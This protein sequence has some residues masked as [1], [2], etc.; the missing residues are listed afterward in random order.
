[1]RL[2]AR[3]KDSNEAAPAIHH[4]PNVWVPAP[5]RTNGLRRLSRSESRPNVRLAAI[6]RIDCNSID[7]NISYRNVAERTLQR[8]DEEQGLVGRQ[9]GDADSEQQAARPCAPEVSMRDE[10][11]AK[12]LRSGGRVSGRCEPSIAQDRGEHQDRG[13]AEPGG[14]H[15][16]EHYGIGDQLHEIRADELPERH[17]DAQDARHCAALFRRNLIREQGDDARSAALNA[18]CAR[19]HQM[20]SV[21]IVEAVATNSSA[22][23]PTSIPATI[24]GCAFE[25]RC[26]AIAQVTEQRPGDQRAR[27]ANGQNQCELP[28][29]VARCQLADA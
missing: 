18:N 9:E 28:R 14:Q 10:V 2:R 4:K 20:S 5:S 7:R 3:S 23:Q 6:T 22:R 15:E 11:D 24:Q 16:R 13:R 25:A 27:R 1:M 19:H 17:A 21:V 26:R 12:A 29:G 8:M